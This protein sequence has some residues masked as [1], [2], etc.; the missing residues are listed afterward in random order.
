MAKKLIDRVK[1]SLQKEGL[2]PRSNQSREWLLSK[3]SS[4][5][6]TRESLM[7]DRKRLKESSIVGKMYFFSYDP[8]TKDKLKYYDTFPLVIPIETYADGFLGLNLHYLHPKN[9]IDLMEKL[10]ETKNKE[11]YD[12]RTKL[13]INY[14]YLKFASKVFESTPCIKRYLFSNIQSRFLEISSDE[15]DIAVLLP[16]ESFV[17]SSKEQVFSDSRKKF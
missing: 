1:E 4:L 10:S 15:W 6:P 13:I 17:G 7:S 12:E 11:T 14:N 9:R 3:V 8:K 5:N 16:V 2:S